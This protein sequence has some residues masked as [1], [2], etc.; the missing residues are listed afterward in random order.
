MRIAVAALAC[1]LSACASEPAR[2]PTAGPAPARY[3]APGSGHLLRETREGGRY[4][5]LEDGSQ[6]E[7]HPRDRFQTAAWEAD[8][9]VTVRTTRAEDGFTYE[10]VNTQA[11]EG[12]LARLLPRP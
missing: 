9:N 6:W 11:D 1:L 7:V 4:L 10:I 5:T 2:A 3:G 8:S 12:A